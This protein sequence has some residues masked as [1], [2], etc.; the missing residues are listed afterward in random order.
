MTKI[1][2]PAIDNEAEKIAEAEAIVWFIASRGDLLGD[3]DAHRNAYKELQNA[4]SAAKAGTDENLNELLFAY[5]KVS[6]FTYAEQGVNGRTILDTQGRGARYKEKAGTSKAGGM[7]F[8]LLKPRNRPLLMGSIL[9]LIVAIVEIVLLITGS[10]NELIETHDTLTT[11]K[12]LMIPSVWGAIGTCTY[13]M[14][15][16]SDRLSTFSFE[17]ERARGIGTRLL[18]GAIL[19]LIVV[20]L[21]SEGFGSSDGFPVYLT[22]FLAGLGIKPVYAAIESL[23]EGL[24]ARIK[25]PKNDAKP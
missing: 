11:A 1:L 2:V 14:K 6:A 24:A 23:V 13:L 7:F 9:M 19:G 12:I 17:E 8:Q 5:S 18:L 10:D 15:K 22:A 16:Q 4:I 3:D 20:E 25:P 21:T